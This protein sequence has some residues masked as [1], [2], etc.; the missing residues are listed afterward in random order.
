MSSVFQVPE[1]VIGLGL[2]EAASAA[3]EPKVEVPKQ[4]AWLN[5]PQRLPDIGLI[6]QLVAG[7]K[8]TMEDAVNMA[9]RLGFP[10][11]TLE[12][13][14]W[15]AQNRLDFAPLLRMWRLSA[16]NP[17][18]DEAGLSALVDK[19]LAHER[20]DWDYQPYLRALKTAE[21]PGIGDIAYGI[22]RGILP[23][24]AW[25]PV[26]PPTQGDKVPRFPV[27]DIDPVL[28]AAGLGFNE[29]MLR[30]LVGRS[31]L[32]MAPIMAANA[33]FRSDA[34]ATINAL[35]GIPGVADFTGE[36]Y[37]GPDDYLLAIAEGDLRTEWADAVRETARQILTAGEYA[38]LQLRGY[39]DKPTRR[40][41]T[42]QHG[43][44][45]FDS[46]LLYDVQGR[47][48]SVH[49][50]LIGLRRGGVYNGPT[51]AI[52][53]VFIEAMERSNLRPEWYNIAYAARE[54]Y[55]SAFVIRALLQGGAIDQATGDD[56]FNKIGWPEDLS[57]TVA[58]HYAPSGTTGAD[59]HVTKAETQLWNTIHT[60]YK[61]GEIDATAATTALPSAGVNPDSVPAI[62]AV[63][64]VERSIP[65]KTLTAAQIKKAYSESAINDAT[66]V[67]WTKD[68]A[69]AAL[70]ALG[71]SAVS[72]NDYL[73]I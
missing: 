35:P 66:G 22:V 73:S 30:L 54:S 33:L 41:L 59:S 40:A 34:A 36:E 15:I 56:L 27:V 67:A 71:Y 29:D 46:D 4:Q 51:D 61:S 31:G 5:N 55:P 72:A 16:V 44:S 17:D 64:D 18:F 69:L 68:D 70:M 42:S 28:L 2:S 8:I 49:T 43:M 58:E 65:R 19:T 20:L 38:E 25:V 3:F 12:S 6:A 32:S 23:A 60:S 7:G 62:L 24:P 53:Q 50:V 52:P 57:L 14:V 10:A 9:E 45:D 37:V 63:W 26:A 11:G 48:P 1:L 13:L 47:A 39:I 21:L